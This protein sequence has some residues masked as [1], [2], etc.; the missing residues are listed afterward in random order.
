MPRGTCSMTVELTV[1]HRNFYAGS[2]QF[3]LKLLQRRL[4]NSV[5][6]LDTRTVDVV[7]VRL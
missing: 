1:P 4:D 7:I 5:V 3:T 2:G 6:V